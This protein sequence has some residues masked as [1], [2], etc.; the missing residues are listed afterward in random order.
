MGENIPRRLSSFRKH[1]LA[2]EKAVT[3]HKCVAATHIFV[4]MIST[5]D[6][7]KKTYALPIQCIPC[8]GLKNRQA[9][10]FCN[11]VVKE[12]EDRNMFV[13]GVIT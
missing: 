9:R 8:Q 5:E 11:K 2:F 12:M 6:R 10:D 13:A 7:R 4:V 3:R 1:L